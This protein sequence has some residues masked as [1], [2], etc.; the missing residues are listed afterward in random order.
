ME[1]EWI[2][3][4]MH[5]VLVRKILGRSTIVGKGK[6]G[7]HTTKVHGG[8]ERGREDVEEGPGGREE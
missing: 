5:S 6:R 2:A 8:K 1:T 4:T 7:V 3:D